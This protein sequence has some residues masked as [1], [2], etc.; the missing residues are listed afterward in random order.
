MKKD[1]KFRQTSITGNTSNNYVKPITSKSNSHR[2]VLVDAL[3]GFALFG[4]IINHSIEHFSLFGGLVEIEFLK[5][6]DSAVEMM[7]SFIFE[8]KSFILFS[9]LL[10]F[11]FWIQYS[12]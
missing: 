12:I 8:G 7:V 5:P 6:L 4:I 1:Q 9:L 3:R 10:G 2:I 11:G